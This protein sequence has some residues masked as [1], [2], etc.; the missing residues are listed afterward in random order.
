MMR[1]DIKCPYCGAE[2]EICHDDGQGYD[3]G[4]I[5]DQECHVCGKNFVFT[6]SVVCYYDAR[7]ADCLNDG[8]HKYTPTHTYPREFSQM[9][10][11]SCGCTRPC[12][13]AEM[14]KIIE[15]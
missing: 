15:G 9:E 6:T 10:C 5:N 14:E 12:T 11:R 3:E 1:S 13:E 2:N 4:V 8:E 7:R